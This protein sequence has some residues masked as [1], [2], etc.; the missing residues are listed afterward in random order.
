[1][2]KVAITA[3]GIGKAYLI[4]LKETTPHTL[5]GALAS[6]FRSP[7]DNFKKIRKLSRLTS[8]DEGNDI[9]WA[10]KD[11]SFQIHYGDVIGIIGNNGAGK[12]SLLKII[13]RITEPTSGSMKLYGRVASLL[14]VGTGFHM[15]L[16][17]RENIYLSGTIMGMSKA[18][19]D[20]KF[21]QIAAFSEMEQFL[22]TPV[23][24]YSS[25]MYLRLAFSVAAHLDPDILILDEVLAVGDAAFKKKCVEKIKS[26]A[27]RDRAI[28]FVSH[29]MDLIRSLC[30]KCMI[31]DTGRIQFYGEVPEGIR[32]FLSLREQRHHTI[33][34]HTGF[35]HSAFHLDGVWVNDTDADQFT[36]VDKRQ[37]LDLR[38]SG[39]LSESMNLGVEIVLHDAYD[40]VLAAHTPDAALMPF[41][42]F[43]KG[44][45]EL[46]HTVDIPPMMKG[47]YSLS[48]AVL[49]SKDTTVLSIP[50]AL[51]LIA[52]GPPSKSVFY[53]DS[54]GISLF[55]ET[56]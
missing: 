17:G 54:G 19:V 27:T 31:L 20:R 38:I 7:A 30:N 14:E 25:G 36:L 11:V 33:M 16:T 47:R 5:K 49:T 37:R 55:G 50:H 2:E 9:L 15:E 41:V 53:Q 18:E 52:D 6:W 51:A 39:K 24:R 56:R 26:F 8:L 3:A 12:S 40:R 44:P 22:D 45:V 1:M 4:G 46:R 43:E 32:T 13:S 35:V 10:L 42:G 23:K 28:L 48:I 29:N 34:S 21:D